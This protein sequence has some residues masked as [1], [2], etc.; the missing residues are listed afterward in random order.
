VESRESR[1]AQIT[2]SVLQLL[3][4]RGPE[5][6]RVS[7]VAEKAGISRAWIYKYVARDSEE[8]IR[9]AL[10]EFARE[11]NSLGE[12]AFEGLHPTDKKR[13]TQVLVHNTWLMIEFSREHPVMIRLLFR[14][15]GSQN[16]VGRQVESIVDVHLAKMTALLESTF[17]QPPARAAS[18]CRTMFAI[19][20]GLIFQHASPYATPITF[21]EFSEN[22]ALIFNR[23]LISIDS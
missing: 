22:L 9:F 2:D 19:R 1:I 8:L 15:F 4:A 18:L 17:G 5:S 3:A 10:Q 23:F 6:V 14:Y 12:K 11:F 20:I 16:I 21:E 7:S 13:F